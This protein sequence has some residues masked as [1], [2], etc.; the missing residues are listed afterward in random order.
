MGPSKW[1]SSLRPCIAVLEV[2]L[3][4]WVQSQAVSQLAVNGKP[5]RRCSIDPASF[6]LGEG[7]AGR[8]ILVASH[9]SDTCGGPGTCTLTR[10]QVYGVWHAAVL[11]P[12]PLVLECALLCY[13]APHLNRCAFLSPADSNDSH[14]CVKLA[15]WHLGGGPFLIHKGNC[16]P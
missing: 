9:S 3:Q 4:T 8:D 6:G 2:S 10:R 12:S 1:D 16:C 13:P 15:G 7:L 11:C 14:S 5:M